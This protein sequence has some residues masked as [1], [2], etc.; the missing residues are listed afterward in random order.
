MTTF[1]PDN[2]PYLMPYL[3]VT[4]PVKAMAEYNESFGMEAGQ[5]ITDDDGVTVF[6]EMNYQGQMLIMLGKEG[7][8]GD[9]ALAPIHEGRVS[10]VALYVYCK[11]VDALHDRAG[12]RGI[13]V[14]AQPQNMFWG[15]RVAKFKDTNGHL[16]SF[17]TRLESAPT[18]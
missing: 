5:T 2:V 6:G 1:K 9:Q 12:S 11:D 18:M 8:F 13:E 7:S 15:D 10:P 16:W 17:A 4:D 14:L 3:T